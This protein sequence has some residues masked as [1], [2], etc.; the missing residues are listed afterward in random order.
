MKETWKIAKWELARNLRNKQFIIGLLIS[1]LIMALFAGVPHLLERWNRPMTA[2]FYVV[3]EL[4]ILSSFTTL[5]DYLELRPYGGE[6]DELGE[7]VMEE[8][9]HGYFILTREFL[10]TGEIALYSHRTHYEASATLY[11]LLTQVLQQHRLSE[12]QI[13]ASELAYLTS[14]AHIHTVALKEDKAESFES[15][16][17]SGAFAALLILL[18]FSSGT[19]LMQSALQER[20]DRM[21]EIIL[22]SIPPVHLMQGKILGHF[23]LGLIQLG[24]WI[25]LGLPVVLFL[26]D[27]PLWEALASAN[28]FPILFF[29][30]LGYL[31]FASLYVSIG[32]TMEDLQSAGNSQSLVVMLPAFSILFLA[33]VISNPEGIIAQATSLFP[34]TSPLIMILRSGLT[35]IPLWEYV[36][37]SVLLLVTTFLVT[38]LASKVFRV[39]ML[40]YG[41]TADL[42]EIMKWLRYK[43]K[44][45]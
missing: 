8:N 29:G 37:S 38:R 45:L 30:L 21:A 18:V 41:K 5:P 28:L 2:V 11:G 16:I 26:T 36:L 12:M 10:D 19:M 6:Q 3:D 13:D 22:S 39:G 1:P 4:E 43:E 24:V 23:I 14:P 27:F 9:L 40:M 35:T 20:R 15:L 31:L 32:A 42:G 44:D 34:I 7:R 33:P 25:V 17:V